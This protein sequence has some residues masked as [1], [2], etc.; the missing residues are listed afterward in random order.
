MKYIVKFECVKGTFE[1]RNKEKISYETLKIYTLSLNDKAVT[2]QPNFKED[3]EYEQSVLCGGVRERTRKW[4]SAESIGEKT[5]VQV[6]VFDVISVPKKNLKD[7]LGVDTFEE[8][9]KAFARDYFLHG[10]K[11]TYTQNDYGNQELC[12]LDVTPGTVLD[13]LEL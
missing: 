13:A 2:W 4:V 11:P 7:V 12:M 3:S 10:V 8:F 1:N 6:P 5:G 9:A